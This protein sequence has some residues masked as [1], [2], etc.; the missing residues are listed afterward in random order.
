MSWNGFKLVK[1]VVEKTAADLGILMRDGAANPILPSTRDRILEIPGR[2]GVFYFGADLAE[3]RI[4]IPCAFIDASNVGELEDRVKELAAFL[5][6]SGTG[7]PA[8][9]HLI[10]EAD[11]IIYWTVYYSGQLSLTRTVFDGHF[12]L[13]FVAPNPLPEDVET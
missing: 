2:D 1:G 8:Q 12:D 10:F 7:K 3:R 9:L 11:P 6:D 5:V 4:T 13:P